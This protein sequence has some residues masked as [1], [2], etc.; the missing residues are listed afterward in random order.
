MKNTIRYKNS[1]EFGKSLG[2]TSFDL[3]IIQQKKRL[4]EKLKKARVKKELSQAELAKIVESK[5]PAI[6]RMEAGQVSQVSMDFLIRVAIALKVSVIIKPY[7][8][9]GESKPHL[10]HL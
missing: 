6:A 7:Q 8:D 1:E 3:E 10:H 4:I 2:L 5:Q 9:T